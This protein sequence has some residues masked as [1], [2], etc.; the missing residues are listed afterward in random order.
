[1]SLWALLKRVTIALALLFD[2]ADLSWSLDDLGSRGC[3]WQLWGKIVWQLTALLLLLRS[4][5]D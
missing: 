3:Y 1:M 4:G 2:L 5:D